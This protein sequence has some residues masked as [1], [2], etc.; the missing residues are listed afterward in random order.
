MGVYKL[1]LKFDFRFEPE[2]LLES[3]FKRVFQARV[4]NKRRIFVEDYE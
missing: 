2:K 4:L 3:N 1:N